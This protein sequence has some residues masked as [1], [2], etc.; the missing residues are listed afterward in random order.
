MDRIGK[1]LLKEVKN[2]ITLRTDNPTTYSSAFTV[3]N[4]FITATINGQLEFV[5]L[6]L[7]AIDKSRVLV[8][9]EVGYVL[10]LIHI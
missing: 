10:S 3:A 5:P 6:D 1:N 8:D 7:L 9:I 2:A 4:R